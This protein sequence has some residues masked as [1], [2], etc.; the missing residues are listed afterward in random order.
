MMK[1]SHF[2]LTTDEN[3][4][5]LFDPW[6][7]GLLAGLG[8]TVGEAIGYFLGYVGNKFVEENQVNQFHTLIQKHPK[9][10]PL[11]LW[12]L[13]ATP[14]PDDVVIIPL[15]IAKYPFW[16]VCVP[17]FIG[18][19]MFLTGV[20]WAGRLSLDLIEGFLFGDPTNPVSK[21]IEVPCK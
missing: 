14:I 10:T 18:K 11:V 6:I 8:A 2:I 16:K 7:I 19:T 4:L 15:G 3:G 13:A 21:S 20:A 12:F 5:F 9:L 1:S 17:Q